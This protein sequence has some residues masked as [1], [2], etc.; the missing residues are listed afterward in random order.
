MD[1]DE[2]KDENL[3]LGNL[4]LENCVS[5]RSPRGSRS[6]RS[7]RSPR[8]RESLSKS[9]ELNEDME[10]LSPNFPY[11]EHNNSDFN[12]IA[13]EYPPNI[14]VKEESSE[15]EGESFNPF[16]MTYEYYQINQILE[17]IM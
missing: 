7:P 5:P 1:S 4:D 13:E 10:A 12:I 8:Q 17:E 9:I 11:E 2:S 6:P 16:F 15:G 14:M 3:S